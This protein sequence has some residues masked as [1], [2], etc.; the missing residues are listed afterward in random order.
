MLRFFFSLLLV[1]NLLSARE[2][3]PLMDEWQF[4]HGEKA[5]STAT[6]WQTVTLP[7][8]W[9]WEMGPR[10][11]GAQSGNGGFRVGG[12][13]RYQ[14]RFQLPDSFVGKKVSI[15]F[16][17]VY[18]DSTVSINGH[19]L[20]NRPYGYIPF[21]YDLSEHLKKGSN[22]IEVHVNNSKEPSTRWHHPCGIYA[23]VQLIA[24]HPQNHF[25]HDSTFITT[26]S[27]SSKS[28][29]VRI[30]SEIKNP[31]GLQ[32]Q[33]RL[34]SSDGTVIASSKTAASA[35]SS[36][37]L[38]VSRPQLW[39]P[40]SPS[41]YT[42][43]LTLLK[44]ETSLDTTT[45]T[46]GIRS[47]KWDKNTG[48]H[49]NGK[50]TK[51][52]GVCEHLTGGPVGGAWT[53]ELLE[54]KLRELKAMGCNAIRTAHNPH[55]HFF[56][57]LCDQLGIL[58]MDEIFDGWRKKAPQ[59]YGAHY[60]EDWWQR[61][62]EAWVRRDRNHPSIV[63]WSVGNETHGKV[64]PDLVKLVNKFDPTRP[65]TSGDSNREKMDVIG[66]NGGSEKK[67]FFNTGPFD[68]AFIATE[69]PHTWQVR[70]FY[71][72]KTW[73]RDGY[74]NKR[75]QPFFIPDLTEKEIFPNACLPPEKMANR[76]QIFLSSY[77]NGTVR[78]N[79]RQHWEKVRDLPWLSGFF[80]WTGFDYPGEASYVHGG[81]PFHAFAGG[82]ND[83]AGFRKD[84][85]YFYQSQWTDKPMVHVLPHWTHPQIPE[86]TLIPV[87]A[88]S[89]ADEVEL[90]LN[91]KSLGI[92]KP[93]TIANEMQCQWMVPWQPGTLVAIAKTGGQEVAR[94]GHITASS[95]TWLKP[96]VSNSIPNHPLITIDT[97][98]ASGT[99]QPYGENTIFAKLTG[100]ARL[101]SFENGNPADPSPP[102][103]NKRRAFMGKARIFLRSTDNDYQLVLGSILGERRQLNSKLTAIDVKT[104]TNGK[105][106][107]EGLSIH[108]TLDG[109]NPTPASASYVG[110]FQTPAVCTVKAIVLR[111]Q[112]VILNL[113]ETFGPDLGLHW[114]APGE[115]TDNTS[116]TALQAEEAKFKGAVISTNAKGYNGKGFLDFKG[117]EGFIEFYQENDG[118]P[119]DASLLIRIRKG[120][121]TT[122][123]PLKITLNGKSLKHPNLRSNRSWKT[124]KIPV[125]IQSGANSLRIETT[126]NS[127]P[128]IDEVDFQ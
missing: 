40:D 111:D 64:A 6:D 23:P 51:L 127:A 107:T 119:G 83:L 29:T 96:S 112:E 102:V 95:P 34:K 55:H 125:K 42:A 88:Y 92:D 36:V 93:G 98:D 17:G 114:A 62:L 99:F 101:L 91:G 19:K 59:D 56:Y 110:P 50:V 76:K 85:F 21:H 87:Q 8:D 66:I 120:D 20:G 74:P 3:V 121:S 122:S 25:I 84:L 79:A 71:K 41:L 89:N 124:V 60:F 30:Q 63:I 94:T 54:W 5:P 26:P 1:V 57:D 18:R 115:A 103:A 109:S 116:S 12:I 24:T 32:L 9:S 81:W 117:K 16:D 128:Q 37:Q 44:N 78:I 67:S 46:F 2:V 86:G 31:N 47:I 75:Q 48:F 97:V 108:Y 58:V 68:R 43:E 70:G 11:G 69:A 53:P 28:A 15:H 105:I 38:K 73:Y 4:S 27:I 100:N 113:E 10:K 22:L 7:H 39:E 65:V 123:T 82:T 52:R 77:D 106:V 33:V 104:I 90:F 13:G 80:R 45:T 118:P 72:S 126:G 14:K 61:D 35:S 49:L